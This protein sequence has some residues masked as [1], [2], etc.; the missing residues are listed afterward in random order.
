[1]KIRAAIGGQ[2]LKDVYL[3][4]SSPYLK[5]AFEVAMHHHERYDGS[6]YPAASS[7][8]VVVP[9]ASA[10]TSDAEPF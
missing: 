2:L 6:G 8:S 4:N 5:M 3:K 9:S 1:M 7:V 10:P